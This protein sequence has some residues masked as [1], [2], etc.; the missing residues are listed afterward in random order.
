MN[1]APKINIDYI[2]IIR[3]VGKLVK[4][5][6]VEIE[7]PL[8]LLSELKIMLDNPN[9]TLYDLQNQMTRHF[10][11]RDRNPIGFLSPYSYYSSY[12]EGVSFPEIYTYDTFCQLKEKIRKDVLKYHNYSLEFCRKEYGEYKYQEKLTELIKDELDKKKEYYYYNCIRYIDAYYYR[13]SL[14]ECKNQPEIKMYSR[15][16]IG[17][18]VFDYIINPDIKIGV[19]SNF[20]YG[21]SSYFYIILQY[22]GIA[23]LPYSFLVNYFYADIREIR[24]YTRSYSAEAENWNFAFDFV[25]EVVNLAA[26]DQVKFCDDFI[27]NEVNAMISGLEIVVSSPK[28]YVDKFTSMKNKREIPPYLNVRHISSIEEDEYKSYPDDIPIAIMSEK[29]S[30]AHEFLA[31]LSTL[32]EH[33]SYANEAIEKIHELTAKAKLVAEPQKKT[34]ERRIEYLTPQLVD[35]KYELELYNEKKS[36]HDTII[37]ELYESQKEKEDAK[38]LYTIRV[39]YEDAHPEYRDIKNNISQKEK[40]IRTLS[41]EIESRN[42][43]IRRLDKCL[44]L[45]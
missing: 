21:N 43:F 34:N 25:E 39:E 13:K 37:K 31:N 16:E 8:S 5:E 10:S 4:H 27:R 42:S 19:Y 26:T 44:N 35:A 2:S 14:S 24:Q 30:D 40:E 15:E 9:N 32:S 20:G 23:I 33:F 6:K 38:S 18:S 17:W 45:Q 7:K 12:V 28:D 36:V 41:D 1:R 3:Q 22:K 29:I 11:E